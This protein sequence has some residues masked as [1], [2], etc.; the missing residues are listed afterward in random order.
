MDNPDRLYALLPPSFRQRDSESGLALGRLMTALS[1][2]Y[3]QLSD[4]AEALYD[5]WFIETCGQRAIPLIGALFGVDGDPDM[6][7]WV[8]SWRRFVANAAAYQR[9]KGSGATLACAAAAASGWPALAHFDERE[10]NATQAVGD[11]DDARATTFAVDRDPVRAAPFDRSTRSGDLW[12]PGA[13]PNAVTLFLWRLQVYPVTRVSPFALGDGR[14][15]V[16]SLGIERPMFHL[17]ATRSDPVYDSEPADL[18][19]PLTRDMLAE[20]C[21]AAAA[22]I[23]APLDRA[24]SADCDVLLDGACVSPATI[25]VADLSDWRFD[26]SASALVAIDPERGRLLVNP[27]RGPAEIQVSYCYAQAADIGGGPYRRVSTPPG[28]VQHIGGSRRRT[29]LEHAIGHWVDGE[30]GATIEFDDSLTYRGDLRLQPVANGRRE[31]L[32]IRARSGE[33]PCLHGDIRVTAGDAPIE[34][35]FDGV[36]ILGTLHIDGDV[37][38]RLADCTIHPAHAAAAI[39]LHGDHAGKAGTPSVTIERS[40][41]GRIADETSGAKL[42]FT[43]SLVHGIVQ[44]ERAELEADRSTFLAPVDAR[45]V[46]ARDTIFDAPLYVAQSDDGGLRNCYVV[47]GSQ[48]PHRFACQPKSTDKLHPGR[49]A[50]IFVGRRIGD[51][52]FGQLSERTPASILEGAENGFEMGCFNRTAAPLRRAAL[53]RVIADYA[54]WQ[55]TVNPVFVT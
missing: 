12:V 45:V 22:A 17:P 14:Y 38:V 4:S 15:L 28:P 13:E 6:I 53:A 8:P 19:V 31:A 29:T 3:Q 55:W 11:P 48:T 42:H 27:A 35:A 34:V 25:A 50:P 33:M 51:P 46:S 37:R 36:H 32:T 7:E 1:E 21:A 30:G 9:R 10:I 39:R 18:P 52:G 47:P 49:A 16:D 43:D 23:N 44:A 40:I 26:W 54:P 24:P 41:V 20:S 5:Q 2:P